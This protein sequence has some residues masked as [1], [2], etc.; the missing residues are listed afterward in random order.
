[1][2]RIALRV[3]GFHGHHFI[4]DFTAPTTFGVSNNT[5]ESFDYNNCFGNYLC[6][7]YASFTLS[8]FYLVFRM[9]VLV[10]LCALLCAFL[11]LG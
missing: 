2:R 1:M 8:Y 3:R 6:S 11:S 9:A 4:L 7:G 10:V 5:V